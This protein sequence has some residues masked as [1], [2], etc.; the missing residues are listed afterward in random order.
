MG[1]S[2]F[3]T[4]GN[5]IISC[6][7]VFFTTQLSIFLNLGDNLS[8]NSYQEDSYWSKGWQTW[9][10]LINY[11]LE[12]YNDLVPDMFISE[13][14]EDTGLHVVIGLLSLICGFLGSCAIWFRTQK[15]QMMGTHW[16]CWLFRFKLK[17][18]KFKNKV[19]GSRVL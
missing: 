5:L 3:L 14:S 13:I 11:L 10:I 18:I 1:S 9:R 15:S 16:Y 12:E 8:N 2:S 6:V 17:V 4:V 7:L 19:R